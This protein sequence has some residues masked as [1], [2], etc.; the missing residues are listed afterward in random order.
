[1]D[2]ERKG[3]VLANM[4]EDVLITGEVRMDPATGK[5][6]SITIQDIERPEEPS[7]PTRPDPSDSA[8]LWDSPKSDEK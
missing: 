6:S 4:L 2:E 8:D 3:A 1:M 7:D 5:V